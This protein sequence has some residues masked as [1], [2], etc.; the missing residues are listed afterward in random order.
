M[1]NANPSTPSTPSTPIVRTPWG[2]YMK[3]CEFVTLRAATESGHV[4]RTL[5]LQELK[6]GCPDEVRDWL[7]DLPGNTYVAMLD[8]M[9]ETILAG[10][11]DDIQHTL[12]LPEALGLTDIDEIAAV[13]MRANDQHHNVSVDMMRDDF[14][15]NF[16]GIYGSWR[17]YSDEL[18]DET[19]PLT[20]GEESHYRVIDYEAFARDLKFDYSV[21]D[22]PGYVVAVYTNH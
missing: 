19:M 11:A 15:D 7:N 4:M 9:Q 14:N 3:Q 21:Y 2:E 16:V 10:Y 12:G 22:L 18:A 5:H 8:W 13:L 20:V 17:E 6:D 1:T